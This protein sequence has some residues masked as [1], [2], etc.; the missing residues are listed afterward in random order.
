MLA[1]YK[2]LEIK[3][4][5]K[6]LTCSIFI[7]YETHFNAKN[8]TRSQL[9]HRTWLL[10]NASFFWTNQNIGW[11]QIYEILI[12][13]L[14]ID[15]IFRLRNFASKSHIS[16]TSILANKKNCHDLGIDPTI[17]MSGPPPM[18]A[19]YNFCRSCSI[20]LQN[21]LS[22]ETDGFCCTYSYS[23]FNRGGPGFS[24][25]TPLLKYFTG[26]NLYFFS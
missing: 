11:L 13:L 15:W 19:G 20:E 24:C 7:F 18:G 22:R 17:N 8:W 25:A 21:L 9:F 4:N 5:C 14:S 23:P 3:R 2:S 12:R 26:F 6:Y 1:T 16:K 10:F